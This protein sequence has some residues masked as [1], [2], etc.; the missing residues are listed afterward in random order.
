[1]NAKSAAIFSRR[2]PLSF[3]VLRRQRKL[4]RRVSGGMRNQIAAFRLRPLLL[5]AA[6]LALGSALGTWLFTADEAATRVGVWLEAALFATQ[7]GVLTALLFA[8][9]NTPARA[10]FAGAIAPNAPRESTASPTN[11]TAPQSAS[12][13]R[14]QHARVLAA[15]ARVRFWR[16]A[17]LFVA[18]TIITTTLAAQRQLPPPRDVSHLLHAIPLTLR[19]APRATLTGEIA[20]PP[21]RNEFNIE[22]PLRCRSAIFRGRSE[23]VSG[24][25]WVTL[26]RPE[27]FAEN[28]NETREYSRDENSEAGAT[29]HFVE[30]D[31]LRVRAVLSALPRARNFGEKSRADFYIARHCWCLA[32]AS[33]F[34]AARTLQSAQGFSRLLDGTRNRIAA[35]YQRRLAFGG[36]AST[37]KKNRPARPYEK[38]TAVLL[39]SLIFGED[40]LREPLPRATRDRYRAAG[41]SH[42]LVSSGT[43]ISLLAGAAILLARLFAL[44]GVALIFATAVPLIFYSALAGGE[45]SIL[46]AAIAGFCVVVALSLGRAIDAL[47]LWSLALAA[48][49][50][51]DP[52]QISNIGLQLSFAATWGLLALSP[53]LRVLASAPQTALPQ[54]AAIQNTKTQSANLATEDAAMQNAAMPNAKTAPRKSWLPVW[55]AFLLAVQLATLPIQI[56]NFGAFSAVALPANALALPLAA[57]VTFFGVLA[58]PF[59]LFSTPAYFCTRW[60]DAAC[61]LAASAPGAQL[62]VAVSGAAILFLALLPLFIC[63]AAALSISLFDAGGAWRDFQ[64]IARHET[65]RWAGRWKKTLRFPPR[66]ALIVFAV[67]AA[68]GVFLLLLNA[69]R[70]ALQIAFLDV[71]QG[72]SIIIRTPSGKTFLIDG[73]SSD[74]RR[75]DLARGVIVPALQNLGVTQL[76]A[77]IMTHADSDHCNA[78][79]GVMREIPTRRVIDGAAGTNARGD[80]SGEYA[81]L[82]RLWRTQNVPVQAARAGQT[83]DCGDGVRLRVLAPRAAMKGMSENNRCAVV[84]LDYEKVSL[85]FT[86]DLEADGENA[87][88]QSDENLRATVLK[89]GH[90]GSRGASSAAF[91]GRVAPRVAVISCGRFNPY[92]HPAPDALARL[93]DAGAEVFRTDRDGEVSLS[94]DTQNCAVTT[95]R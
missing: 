9:K 18:L 16:V 46:R 70:A 43:Q 87:L 39:T 62:S 95:F 78:L 49:L 10:D 93:K 21:R 89:V 12:T 51:L 29:D 30:G 83:I 80:G 3:R 79:A 24:L 8:L 13:A 15:R 90:H 32:R 54:N 68:F 92:G 71:G 48:L 60:L 65:F 72:D 36:G 20:A 77:I 61:N 81:R 17:A 75:G 1:M 84:R 53:A 27:A 64:I 26:P 91:L 47:S 52:A 73:G 11:E 86:G 94:C 66:R 74:A 59:S 40:G 5:I 50:L 58:L 38:S 37:R 2:A 56:A 85:L 69:R 67:A 82:Q 4:A 44:R 33:R 41:L 63:G 35:L 57:C 14:R 88:L 23:T 28:P 25:V 34:G 42:L 76:D 31:L 19:E 7:I 55:L 22:F 45:A 6:A